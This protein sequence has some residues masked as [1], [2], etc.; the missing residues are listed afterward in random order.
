MLVYLFFPAAVIAAG[1]LCE[2]P[3]RKRGISPTKGVEYG[4]LAAFGL[5]V[6]AISA[7]RYFTGSDYGSYAELF[8]SFYFLSEEE[9][10]GLA[11]EK[12]FLMPLYAISPAVSDLRT[13][14][15]VISAVCAVGVT[16]LIKR[17]SGSVTV[18][19]AAFILGG[20][21]FYSMNFLRQFIAGML[22]MAA[23]R[24]A[25]SREFLRFVT[26]ILAAAAFHWSAIILI[27]IYFLLKIRWNTTVMLFGGLAVLGG[28][29]A[30]EFAVN[31]GIELLYTKYKEQYTPDLAGLPVYYALGFS[32]LFVLAYLLRERLYKRSE[33]NVIF[34]NCLFLTAFFEILGIRFA[35]LSR[36]AVLFVLPA[37]L[38]A[39]PEL[40]ICVSDILFEKKGKRGCLIAA[41]V[42]AAFGVAYY[43]CLLAMDGNGVVPYR[44][45]ETVMSEVNGE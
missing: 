29:I 44:T 14:F 11:H 34:V 24:Y 7:M 6:F 42:F 33:M 43:G 22:V 45:Y 30:S 8:R 3:F 12:G 15:A 10:F 37:L 31:M 1:C 28:L 40:F 5:A 36:F 32:A 17:Y 9:L 41:A 2:I 23:L 39:V 20:A 13:F 16:M 21:W 27:P 38:G 18:A 25:E 19:A 35:M 4:F 26:V